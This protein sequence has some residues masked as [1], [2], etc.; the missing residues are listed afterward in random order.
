MD[1]HPNFYYSIHSGLLLYAVIPVP[2]CLLLVNSIQVN[3]RGCKCGVT[4]Y[5]LNGDITEEK[6]LQ[7]E[8]DAKET[9]LK[10]EQID[11][12]KKDYENRIGLINND[13]QDI[14][15][16]LTETEAKGDIVQ[17]GFYSSLNSYENSVLSTLKEELERLRG[18]QDA[19]DIYSPQ[20]YDLQSDIQ[21]VENSISETNISIIENNKKIGELRQAMYDDIAARNS[22][23]SS[24]AQF[25][26][27]L[28]G[29]NLIDDKTG[30][31]TK[32][33]LGVLGTYGIELK[34]NESSAETFRQNREEIEGAIARFNSG[35]A[36]ALDI[37]GSLET[38]EKELND[39]IKKQQE[40]ITAEYSAMKDIY[41]LM[42]KR[43]DAQLAYMNGPS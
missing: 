20:W 25:L 42:V 33:G 17:A 16:S 41:D 2:I 11:N 40:A 15:N 19:F 27:G 38:A 31:L 22:D 18:E 43:Y 37:C 13:K 4:S 21:S 5:Y 30:S 3:P 1:I 28:L 39:A 10:Q 32:E 14:S 7:A 23:A 24:E 12:L 35:D 9:E 29:D 26:A 8:Y 6:R 36:H 34:A